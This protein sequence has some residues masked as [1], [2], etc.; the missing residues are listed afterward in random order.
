MAT[1]ACP[2]VSLESKRRLAGR[3]PCRRQVRKIGLP[4]TCQCGRRRV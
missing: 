4:T 2:E 3:V 1:K